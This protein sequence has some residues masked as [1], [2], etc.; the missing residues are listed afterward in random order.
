MLD[1]I[2]GSIE[3]TFSTGEL[4]NLP[5]QLNR[6]D[7]TLST[8]DNYCTCRKPI[9][10]C[11]VWSQVI[12]QQEKWLYNKNKSKFRTSLSWSVLA[13]SQPFYEAIYRKFVIWL[14]KQN[15][16]ISISDILF[17]LHRRK[18]Q[19][20]WRLIDT[21]AEVS[22]NIFIV[23]SSKDILRFLLLQYTRPE[24]IY[25][26][27]MIRNPMGVCNSHLKHGRNIKC[28]A[29]KWVKKYNTFAKLISKINLDNYL[30]IDYDELTE[31]VNYVRN[32]IA[33]YLNISD[34]KDI[35][36]INTGS[37]HIIAGNH[38]TRFAGNITIVK[39]EEWKSK[40]SPEQQSIISRRV[41]K[42]NPLFKKSLSGFYFNF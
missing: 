4:I 8:K 21:I 27:M 10:E 42:L 36:E 33:H 24:D 6:Q 22:G 32:R 26:I 18:G 14:L 9:K 34:L 2:I 29:S 28:T 37:Y 1:F 38:K 39:D 30:V 23:D 5:W 7:K 35:Q 20:N 13:P 40:L 15:S 41:R 12:A 19:L 16:L 25:L 17:R 31:N 11:H 3:N